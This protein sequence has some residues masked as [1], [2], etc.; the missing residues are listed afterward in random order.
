MKL[1]L[2]ALG[3]LMA[4]PIASASSFSDV[5][6]GLNYDLLTGT[7]LEVTYPLSKTLQV[8]GSISN[9]IGLNEVEEGV[10]N[11]LDY[12]VKIDGGLTRI[13]LDY[14]PF[15]GTFFLS[16]GYAFS[17]FNISGS[18]SGTGTTNVGNENFTGD[19]TVNSDFSWDDGLSLTLGWGRSPSKGLGFIL[20]IGVVQTGS[21][22]A[23]ISGTIS[24]V[25]SITRDRFNNALREEEAEIEEDFADFDALPIIQIGLSYRF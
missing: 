24:G 11:E 23:T 4:P 25:D 18:G 14:H 20:E 8:R 2:I 22:E 15:Q 17:D 12:N 10:G 1:T 3:A 6:V 5:G 7:G 9:G 16:V 19:V 13:V 21:P